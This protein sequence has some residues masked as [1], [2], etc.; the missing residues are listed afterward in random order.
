MVMDNLNNQTYMKLACEQLQETFECDFVGLAFQESKGP[1]IGW[2]VASGNSND[3]YK[4]ITLR[5][6]KGIAG[7]VLSTGRPMEIKYFPQNILGKALEYPILLAEKLLYAYAVPI[8]INGVPKGVLLV[9]FRSETFID[10]TGKKLV[11][12]AAKEL[13]KIFSVI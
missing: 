4:R 6:G 2:K 10:D 1:N 9:G 13:E 7:R 3:K 11:E 8:F 12:K 5:Y